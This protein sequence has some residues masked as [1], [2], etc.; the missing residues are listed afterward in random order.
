MSKYLKY[1]AMILAIGM[2]FSSCF[3]LYTFKDISIKP[4]VKTFYVEDFGNVAPNSPPT[5]SQEFSEALREK[6][7]RET[8]LTQTDSDPDVTFSGDVKSFTITAQAPNSNGAE[9]NR[10][11]I[12]IQVDY[13]NAKHEDE[14]WNKPF[15]YY[16]DFPQE[17]S[18]EDVQ[19]ALTK[20]IFDN[21]L[22]DIIN[23]AF[24]NW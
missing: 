14:N 3:F 5:I 24:N 19:E 12:I 1:T 9:L 7:V 16:V 10:L 6:V 4:D 20:E 2:S 11:E 13:F 15:S 8:S 23:K 21:I 18:F 17:S 22:E